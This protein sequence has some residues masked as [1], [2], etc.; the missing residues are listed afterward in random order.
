MKPSWSVA[1]TPARISDNLPQPDGPITARKCMRRSRRSN[2][3]VCSSRPKNRW[4][5]VMSNRRSPT[6]GLGGSV[7]MAG[8]G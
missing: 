2:S 4:L 1:I 8:S 5:S 7:D 6:K 3:W